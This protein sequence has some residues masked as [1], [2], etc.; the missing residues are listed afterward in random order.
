MDT[1][2]FMQTRR[3]F[4]LS[5]ARR[6]LKRSGSERSV[7]DRLNYYVRTR[8]LLPVTRGVYAAVP[9]GID[10]ARFQPD[11]F[12]IGATLRP[13]GVFGY[14][15]AL[16]LLGVA[17][18]DWN[19]VTVETVRR[20]RRLV[21]GGVRLEFVAPPRAILPLHQQ[22][23]G[24]TAVDRSGRA[25]RV[26][27][28]ERTLV[29]GLREPGRC[30]GIGELVAAAAGFPALDLDLV[31]RFLSAFDEKVLWASLGWFLERHRRSFSVSDS[32]LSRL[33]QRR[34][35]SRVYLAR[36]DGRGR[37]APRWNLILPEALMS[38]GEPDE[39]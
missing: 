5:E 13:D 36:G 29:E 22:R 25:L 21:V 35:R 34:P 26:T 7:R 27:G 30:G 37:L 16:S 6:T 31:D 20:R 39:R 11:P 12:L 28:P 3:V 8:R 33:E 15:S 38:P 4:T 10:S 2:T 24:M 18:V 17:R 1:W 32:F 9:P 14:Y 19:V 23:V